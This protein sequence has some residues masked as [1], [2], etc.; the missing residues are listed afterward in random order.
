MSSR[1]RA[2]PQGER[3]P[4]PRVE[5]RAETQ[6]SLEPSS[7][8]RGERVDRAK[9]RVEHRAEMPIQASNKAEQSTKPR[10]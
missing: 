3:D 6:P 4:E 1:Y 2:N 7:E 9:L 10:P 8:S 5:S